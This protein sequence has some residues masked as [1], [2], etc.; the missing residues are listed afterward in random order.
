MIYLKSKFKKQNERGVTLLLSLLVLAALSAIVF[1]IA[2]IVYNEVRTSS[3]LTK[4]EPIIT[5]AEAV[6]EDALFR[7]IRGLSTLSSC[8]SP[9]TTTLNGVVVTSCASYYLPSPNILTLAQS[10]R[11]DY[12]L[13]NPLDQSQSP[14]YTTVSIKINSGFQSTVY[15]CNWADTDCPTSLTPLDVRTIGSAGPTTT[16]TSP[17]LNPSSLYIL[18]IIDS[19]VDPAVFTITSSPTGLPAGTT[20]IQETGAKQGLTRKLQ[21]TV[22]Q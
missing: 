13:Y 3:D 11:K 18:T 12:Y 6:A 4:T 15:F 16:W 10:A 2:A 19:A 22:P 17:V 5:G 1:S 21:I 20:T 8:T 7:T 14:G 9:A